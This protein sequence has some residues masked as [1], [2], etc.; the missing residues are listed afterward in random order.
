[1][2]PTWDS[3]MTY[4]PHVHMIFPCD[5]SLADGTK[6]IASRKNF[7]LSLSVLSRLNRR[8]TLEGLSKL[9]KTGKLNCFSNQA[10]LADRDSFEAFLTSLRKTRL[11]RLNLHLSRPLKHRVIFGLTI[12]RFGRDGP[13]RTLTGGRACCGAA[14]RTGPSNQ[15]FAADAKF[16]A[17]R[18][19]TLR[20]ERPFAAVARMAG[21]GILAR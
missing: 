18:T 4:H 12:A 9:H 20:T 11:G 3:A 16:N 7:F 19:H 17:D 5:D 14:R 13:F 15:P 8:L 6:W 2:L 21:S 10:A 1:M